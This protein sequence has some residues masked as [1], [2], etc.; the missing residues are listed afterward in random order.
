MGEPITQQHLERYLGWKMQVKNDKERL[1]HAEHEAMWPTMGESN[2]SQ[3]QPGKGDRMECAII[4]K[5]ELD[6]ELLH[7]IKDN[8]RKMR[9][10]TRAINGL[11]NPYEQEVLWLTYIDGAWDEELQQYTNVPATRAEVALKMRGNDDEAETTWVKRL[12]KQALKSISKFLFE[13]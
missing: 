4:R 13:E 5:I 8:E 6:E 1:A 3:H 2:G 9:Q 10:I 11:K 7:R 12:H